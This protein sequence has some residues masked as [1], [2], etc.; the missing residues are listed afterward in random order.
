MGYIHLD[1]SQNHSIDRQSPLPV[2]QQI[3]FDI[4]ARIRQGEWSIGSKIPS[5]T[6]LT[7]AYEVSRVTI[8]QAL[9]KL[10]QDGLIDKQRGRGTYVKR[11]PG[12]MIQELFL[13]QNSFKPK[14]DVES[15]N[16]RIKEIHNVP[17][18][19]AKQLNLSENSSAFYLERTFV[20]DGRVAAINTAWFPA[21]MT[22]S[23]ADLPLKDNSVTK[24]LQERYAITFGSVHNYIEA[25]VMNIGVAQQLEAAPQSPALKITSL[26]TN[27]QGIPF[28]YSVTTWNGQDTE[29]HV[30]ISSQQ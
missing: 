11:M 29:F 27:D 13:P 5:E 10:Q 1:I 7:Q 3:A 15:T 28:E 20:R 14:S 4:S 6:E 17:E 30:M 8:H 9:A 2:Y 23:M 16:I 22:P 21:T 26:Y 24:T 25:I 18:N 19:I 12:T